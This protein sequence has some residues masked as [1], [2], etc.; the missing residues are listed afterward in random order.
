MYEASDRRTNITHKKIDIIIPQ[1]PIRLASVRKLMSGVLIRICKPYLVTKR[2][3]NIGC[4]C[5]GSGKEF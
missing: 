2:G 5:C 4:E 1:K 3:N